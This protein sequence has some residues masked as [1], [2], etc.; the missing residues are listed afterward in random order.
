MSP[1]S[2]KVNVEVDGRTLTLTNLDKVLYPE[3][4]FTKG[5]VIDY[6]AKI[7][8]VML[9]HLA[10][11]AATFKRYPNGVDGK[12]FF[13]KNMPSHAPSWVRSVTLPSPGST[14]S[15]ETIDYTV[16][17][18]LP[19]LVWAANLAA[20]ELHIPMWRVGPRGKVHRP[21]PARVRS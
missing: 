6:Y 21:G 16:I 19:T 18:D 9:P 7:A 14:K 4:G 13:E 10:N 8:P 11:R 17:Q 5:E 15:R 1:D 3:A 20:L 12:F 2:A